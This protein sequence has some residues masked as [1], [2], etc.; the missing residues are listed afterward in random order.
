[1]V[2]KLKIIVYEKIRTNECLVPKNLFNS[3]NY[4]N[5]F[6]S[7]VSTETVLMMNEII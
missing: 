6:N 4:N 7:I 5:E 3:M 1:M 2:L